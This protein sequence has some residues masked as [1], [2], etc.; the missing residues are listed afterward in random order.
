MIK[1]LQ[2]FVGKINYHH[3]FIP[4]PTYILVPLYAA[5]A[6]KPKIFLWETQQVEARL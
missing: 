5:M 2:E 3:H 6:G 4:N 1:Q